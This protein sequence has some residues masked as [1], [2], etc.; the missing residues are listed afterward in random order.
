MSGLGTY[1][2]RI[3]NAIALQFEEI[4]VEA[5]ATK[6]VHFILC[7]RGTNL[8]NIGTL[9]NTQRIYLESDSDYRTRLLQVINVNTSTGTKDA[10]KTF[11]ATYLNISENLISIEET[12]SNLNTVYIRMPD[13]YSSRKIELRAELKTV[14]AAGIF[15]RFIFSDDNWD[16][17]E[18]DN[19]DYTWGN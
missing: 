11:I 2:E 8:E 3:I 19:A 18:F 16:E 5:N 9:L 10:I 4:H 7:S 1:R 6:F 12:S 14:I 15:V 13:T 17:A